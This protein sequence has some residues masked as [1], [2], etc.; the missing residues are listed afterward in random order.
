[1]I[2]GLGH[3]ARHGRLGLVIGLLAG[4]L[5]PEVATALRP[6]LPEMIGVLLFLTALRIGWK[7]AFGSLGALGQ[8]LR[9]L[10]G[11]QIAMPVIAFG[12]F[13]AAG[14]GSTPVA[15]VVVLA[16]AAPPITGSPNFAMLLG[17]DPAPALRLLVLGT[18]LFPLTVLPVFWLLPVLGSA[19]AA[20]AA[21]AWL[22]GVIA[23]SVGA[24]FAVRT[25]LLHAPT[26][27]A[28]RAIDGLTVIM[29]AV[30]VVGLMAALGPAIRTQP[31]QFGLW[32]FLAVALNFGMQM[33]AHSVLPNSASRVPFSIIAGNR[34]VAL[35]LVALPSHITDPL[36]I[37]IGC[38]QLPMYLT[39]I[40]M[41]RFYAKLYI[42]A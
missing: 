4:L 30:I 35:F 6:W 21:S 15:L 14:L 25:A 10:L 34:N 7:E 18:A 39:P 9:I 36:L 37:F 31:G 28:I 5:L 3:V 17:H 13:W 23:V 41:K 24:G 40:L 19:G 26:P 1:M 16:L 38:Y 20:F 22:L 8:S 12:L 11:F 32:L 33:L 42:S 2:T 27:D 29:L